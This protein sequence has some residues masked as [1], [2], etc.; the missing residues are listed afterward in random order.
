MKTIDHDLHC[1]HFYGNNA[2][3]FIV[4]NIINKVK[5]KTCGP[6]V[7]FS[8]FFKFWFAEIIKVFVRTW[9]SFLFSSLDWF[10]SFPIV[11]KQKGVDQYTYLQFLPNSPSPWLHS[12]VLVLVQPIRKMLR[13][14]WLDGYSLEKL[15]FS[16]FHLL[17][18]CCSFPSF[19]P[20]FV[21][22]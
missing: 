20:N 5:K 17:Q 21:F 1:Y 2:S 7:S 9:L 19:W 8:I 16:Y 4:L 3:R 10:Q 6:F 22:R 15:C 11:V 13:N 14:Q 18:F 12:G